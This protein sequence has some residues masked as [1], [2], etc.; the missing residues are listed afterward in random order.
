MTANLITAPAAPIA[1][2][3][4]KHRALSVSTAALMASFAPALIGA[5]QAQEAETVTVSASRIVRDGFQAPT[6]TTVIGADDIAAQAAENVYSAVQ[7]L[8][9]LMGSQGVS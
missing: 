7:I 9:S 8:P 5:A 4:R 6:P 1:R 3:H 2:A